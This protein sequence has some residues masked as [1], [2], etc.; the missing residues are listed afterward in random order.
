MKREILSWL[1]CFILFFL[2][3]NCSTTPST[4]KTNSSN[5]TTGAKAVS[6]SS[7]SNELKESLGF[8]S[9][10]VNTVTRGVKDST[11]SINPSKGE[12]KKEDVN[13]VGRINRT[14]NLIQENVAGLPV[15][16]VEIEDNSSLLGGNESHSN[17]VHNIVSENREAK[18]TEQ[19]ENEPPDTDK[20][21]TESELREIGEVKQSLNQKNSTEPTQ[22]IGGINSRLESSIPNESKDVRAVKKGQDSDLESY[23]SIKNTDELNGQIKT[24]QMRPGGKKILVKEEQQEIGFTQSDLNPKDL[25]VSVSKLEDQVR[26]NKN[27]IQGV[28]FSAAHLPESSVVLSSQSELV[29]L[30]EA[31]NKI[32][33]KSDPLAILGD[34]VEGKVRLIGM[35]DH[36]QN[37]NIPTDQPFPKVRFKD[38]VDI[39]PESNNK[40]TPAH[41]L[42]K[43]G[44]TTNGYG[45]IR[46]FLNRNEGT[47]ND[48]NEKGF[49]EFT[50]AKSYLDTER[51]SINS[52][53][54]SE[55][56]G[57]KGR[58]YEKTL[59]WINNRGRS[60]R[61]ATVE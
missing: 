23:F 36:S 39:I 2:F 18:L 22:S 61:E 57:L 49:Q 55:G 41:D 51:K 24:I 27:V 17:T 5:S 45:N 4:Q 58:P 20:E 15:N 8:K 38:K 40:F 10:T 19:G 52:E 6:G 47:K 42:K 25:D 33:F 28:D 48:K 30:N 43:Y 50:R 7:D 11:E 29:P 60:F 34:E 14:E 32:G 13:K 3:S 46:S 35:K 31:N 59:E 16:L 56:L 1:I 9:S 37:L 44:N 12:N 26:T 21:L 54:S 53:I